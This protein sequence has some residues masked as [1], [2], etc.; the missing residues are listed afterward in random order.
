MDVWE[1]VKIHM[2]IY[3]FESMVLFNGNLLGFLRS[4]TI[5]PLSKNAQ[6][7][8]LGLLR[9]EEVT[10][11]AAPMDLLFHGNVK[12]PTP[13]KGHPAIKAFHNGIILALN[14]PFELGMTRLYDWAVAD[15]GDGVPIDSDDD[16][17]FVFWQVLT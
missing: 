10:W 5:L 3:V 11:A 15:W 17:C 2:E 9:Y 16:C 14:C 8:T 13:P 12:G 6:R 7:T 1:K 4:S